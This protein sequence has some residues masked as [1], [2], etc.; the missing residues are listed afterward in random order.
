MLLHQ[1]LSPD[2][3]LKISHLSEH[4]LDIIEE[5]LVRKMFED[6][7]LKTKGTT[8]LKSLLRAKRTKSSDPDK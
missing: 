1:L 3:F 2:E 4:E 8:M 5:S 7:S 6:T